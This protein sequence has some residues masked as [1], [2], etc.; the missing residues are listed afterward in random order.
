MNL[1]EK[2]LENIMDVFLFNESIESQFNL[3]HLKTIKDFGRIKKYIESSLG[4]SESVMSSLY[5]E[6]GVGLFL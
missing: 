3:E 2:Y 6:C 5:L 4:K 1:L